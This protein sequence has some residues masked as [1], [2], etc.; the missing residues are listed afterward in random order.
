M[1]KSRKPSMGPV[2][3]RT[4]RDECE[5]SDISRSV[6]GENHFKFHGWAATTSDEL[7]IL[8]SPWEHTAVSWESSLPLPSVPCGAGS[9]PG[10]L[11]DCEQIR[12]ELRSCT[13]TDNRVWLQG[14]RV[15]LDEL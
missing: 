8:V 3:L 10:T 6:R 1:V 9:Q 15:L 5:L 14:K 11:N 12:E 4:H 2:I 13:S 7:G